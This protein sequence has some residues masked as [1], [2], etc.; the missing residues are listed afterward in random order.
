VEG[1]VLR[2][3]G[4]P[5][6]PTIRSPAEVANWVAAI[7]SGVTVGFDL[8]TWPTSFLILL[9]LGFGATFI[10][11]RLEGRDSSVTAWVWLLV[12]AAIWLPIAFLR[13]SY[14]FGPS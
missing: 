13:H 4:R 6:L 7:A 5:W 11:W 14:P 2:D 9:I 3:P 10:R 8:F 12:A 1:G